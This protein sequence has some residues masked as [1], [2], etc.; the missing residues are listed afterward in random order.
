MSVIE[1]L[2]HKIL[3]LSG[4][5]SFVSTSA[6]FIEGSSISI[7][8][9]GIVAGAFD[10]LGIVAVVDLVILKTRHHHLTFG[11]AIKA[12]APNGPGFVERRLYPEFFSMIAVD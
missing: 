10:A 12:M 6:N 3:V 8:H 9:L 7:G 2:N 11:E 5:T 1:L 4:K